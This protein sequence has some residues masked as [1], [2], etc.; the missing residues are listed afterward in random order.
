MLLLQ[1]WGGRN[2]VN[3]FRLGWAIHLKAVMIRGTIY[4]ER[5]WGGR[6]QW[7]KGLT[8]HA[9][10]EP[11]HIVK[12][13]Y[14]SLEICKASTSFRLFYNF[15][16]LLHIQNML[17][18]N[19]IEYYFVYRYSKCTVCRNTSDWES[20]TLM[21]TSKAIYII[22]AKNPKVNTSVSA[23]IHLYVMDSIN[24]SRSS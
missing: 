19:F 7:K 10:Q 23:E 20:N 2:A 22:F 12:N 17:F 15:N 24:R 14:W 13:I 18:H 3:D 5:C 11:K 16:S 1:I 21:M 9:N 4:G 6:E 8:A